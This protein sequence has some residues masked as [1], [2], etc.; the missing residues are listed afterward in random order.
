MTSPYKSRNRTSDAKP[1]TRTCHL[2]HTAGAVPFIHS[3]PQHLKA[4]EEFNLDKSDSGIKGGDPGTYDH[5]A[6]RGT[7]L[8]ANRC[9]NS[10]T[11]RGFCLM[12]CTNSPWRAYDPVVQL[13]SS[14]SIFSSLF[15]RRCANDCHLHNGDR[16]SQFRLRTGLRWPSLRE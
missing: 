7:K 10:Y 15:N 12:D 4:T 11:A 1:V 3:L 14:L 8:R 9:S 16:L 2:R 13:L 6:N 5:W